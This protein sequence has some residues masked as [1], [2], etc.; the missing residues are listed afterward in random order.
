MK[1]RAFKNWF[2]LIIYKKTLLSTHPFPLRDLERKM[3]LIAM[4][5]VLLVVI[6]FFLINHLHV[7]LLDV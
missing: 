5:C 4:V 7:F 6:C 3:V 1:K 2:V